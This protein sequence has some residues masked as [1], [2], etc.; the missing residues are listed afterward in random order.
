MGTGGGIWGRD[1]E[2]TGRGEKDAMGKIGCGGIDDT[3]RGSTAL[4]ELVSA[5]GFGSGVGHWNLG[6]VR[7]PCICKA[8][9]RIVC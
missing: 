5:L 8:V 6:S 3:R 7:E 1:V 9:F 2:G 4:G